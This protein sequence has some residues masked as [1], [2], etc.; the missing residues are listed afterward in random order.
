MGL[1]ASKDTSY[2][3][4]RNLGNNKDHLVFWWPMSGFGQHCFYLKDAKNQFEIEKK[5]CPD[6]RIHLVK[7]KYY[8][9]MIIGESKEIIEEYN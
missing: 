4:L 8:K 5:E 9:G 7:Y 6:C 3:I 1:T 2:H